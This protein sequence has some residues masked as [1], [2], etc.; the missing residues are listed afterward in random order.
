MVIFVPRGE[1]TDPTRGAEYYD[2]TFEYLVDLGIPVLA[3]AN[4]S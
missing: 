2:P 3:D 1:A 4:A